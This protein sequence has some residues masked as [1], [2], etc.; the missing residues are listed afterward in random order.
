MW[1]LQALIDDR[2]G[3]GPGAISRIRSSVDVMSDFGDRAGLALCVKLLAS[4]SARRGEVAHADRL[5]ALVP[6]PVRTGPPVHLPEL[7]LA[8][9]MTAGPM[10]PL[11]DGSLAE[12]LSG[13]I[14]GKVTDPVRPA[15]ETS[16]VL[17]TR[18]WQI[19]ALVAEGLGNPAIA[20]RLV[21]SRRTVE[22]HVQRILAKLGFRSRSQIAVWVSQ[23]ER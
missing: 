9:S 4:A 23:Q 8:Q 17:S 15:A 20:A 22:G 7:A 12:V 18:E 1:W 3:N 19:A 10:T 2:Q 11:P 21:L 14:D 16:Q 5:A 6:R 13:I